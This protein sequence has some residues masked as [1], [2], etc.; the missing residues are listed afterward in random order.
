MNPSNPRQPLDTY[1]DAEEC[2]AAEFVRDQVPFGQHCMRDSDADELNVARDKVKRVWEGI[3]QNANRPEFLVIREQALAR[4]RRTHQRRWS[5]PWTATQRFWAIAASVVGIA[6]AAG[7]AWQLSP[8]GYR[9]GVYQTGFGEQRTIELP[10]NS[11]IVLDSNTKIRATLTA[12]A[13]TIEITQGQAQFNVIHDSARPFKVMVGGHTIVDVGTV[14]TVEYVDQTVQVALIEGKVAVLTSSA[15]ATAA[16]S[17]DS[18][19]AGVPSAAFDSSVPQAIQLSAGEALR[20]AQNGKATLT[21]K[22]DIQAAT[23]WRDGEVIFHAEPLSE[24][25]RRLNRY[26]KIKLKIDGAE[27]ASL[28]VSGVFE[29]GDSRAFVDAVEAYLPV[30]A[31]YSESG[32]IKLRTK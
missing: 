27:L 19:A 20:F 22:A 1:S 24:A 7:L 11:R 30:T 10:D 25:V 32:V 29:A 14:F 4:A 16:T 8:Y 13:R 17:E 18:S 15:E 31:D 21:P 2:A 6:F 26:S 12:D 28:S 9:P 5:L 23:A 3:G